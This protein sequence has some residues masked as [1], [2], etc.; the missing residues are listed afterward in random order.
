MSYTSVFIGFIIF[1]VICSFI[2]GGLLWGMLMI[3]SYFVGLLL[4]WEY[5]Q[6]EII[7]HQGRTKIQERSSICPY[8][9]SLS[10]I[11][12]RFITSRGSAII[13]NHITD[14]HNNIHKISSTRTD[15]MEIF[16]KHNAFIRGITAMYCS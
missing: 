14:Y 9:Y 2:F 1:P 3:P 6:K 7:E 15:Y 8:Q 16:V 11:T 12:L 10:S 13:D 5:V 4:V